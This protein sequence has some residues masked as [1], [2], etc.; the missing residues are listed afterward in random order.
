VQTLLPSFRFLLKHRQTFLRNDLAFL[1]TGFV[2]RLGELS[3]GE[4]V[5]HFGQVLDKIKA[6][7]TEAREYVWLISD[8]PIV[9]GPAVGSSFFSRDLP[10]RFIGEKGND[11]ALVQIAAALPNSEVRMMPEVKIAMGI[12][13]A[14]AGVIFPGL[15]GEIDFGAGFVGKD[16]LFRTWC[17]DLFETFWSRSKGITVV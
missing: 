1:P 5:N 11:K 16:A 3:E 13:E 15:S 2:E 6:A 9:V 4:F 14:S 10:V 17:S 7:I 8:Q 12:N